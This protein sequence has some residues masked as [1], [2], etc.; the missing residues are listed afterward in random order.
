LSPPVAVAGTSGSSVVP[1]VGVAGALACTSRSTR[2]RSAYATA[3][4]A[5]NG[6]S[7]RSMRPSAVTTSGPMPD[8]RVRPRTFTLAPARVSP[9]SSGGSTGSRL[10]AASGDAFVPS[11]Q[12][13]TQPVWTGVA[14]EAVC[15]ISMDRK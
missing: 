13:P 4:R 3:A 7:P 12:R 9:V 6:G 1:G 14:G 5:R 10:T 11:S 8:G 15:Q 2:I